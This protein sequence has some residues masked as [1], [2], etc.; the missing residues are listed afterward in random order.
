MI[1]LFFLINIY[2]C[3]NYLTFFCVVYRNVIWNSLVIL[4]IYCLLELE[5]GYQCF[6]GFKCMDFEDLGFSR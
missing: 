2:S 1:I 5:E 3:G 6:L 4:D